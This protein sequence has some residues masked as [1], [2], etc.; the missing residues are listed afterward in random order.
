MVIYTTT[1]QVL[2]TEE[3]KDKE[4]RHYI[5]LRQ[6]FVLHSSETSVRGSVYAQTSLISWYCPS[7]A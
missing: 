4:Q 7:N 5:K 1:V 6:F 3:I 2:A